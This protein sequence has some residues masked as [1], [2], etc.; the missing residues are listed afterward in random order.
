[1][2]DVLAR[3][4]VEKQSNRQQRDHLRACVTA[5]GGHFEQAL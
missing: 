4:P 1:V 5:D 3:C 2:R